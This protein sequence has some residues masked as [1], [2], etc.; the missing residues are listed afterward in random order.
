MGKQ[1]HSLRLF[2]D[3]K[4]EEEVQMDIAILCYGHY[5]TNE[6]MLQAS[7]VRLQVRS[8]TI[9]HIAWTDMRLLSLA[10]SNAEAEREPSEESPRQRKKVRF[11]NKSLERSGQ[12]TAAS[13][14]E[15]SSY[16]HAI[17]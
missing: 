1:R 13:K 5:I 7:L 15:P 17:G 3:A 16:R 2:L 11:A 14:P 9:E 4:A 12:D 8:R 10:E 6:T